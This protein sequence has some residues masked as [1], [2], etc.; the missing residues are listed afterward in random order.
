MSHSV[1][2]LADVVPPVRIDS[3]ASCMEFR[4]DWMLLRGCS[5]LRKV[6]HNFLLFLPQSS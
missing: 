4:A 2:F 6:I 3:F 5:V 1:L